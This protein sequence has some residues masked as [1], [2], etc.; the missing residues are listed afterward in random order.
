MHERGPS[1]NHETLQLHSLSAFQ[2]QVMPTHRYTHAYPKTMGTHTPSKHTGKFKLVHGGK[3][4]PTSDAVNVIYLK[5]KTA[6]KNIYLYLLPEL[7]M[8]SVFT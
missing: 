5:N 2:H 8:R 1:F 4:R 3:K 6:Q 7:E